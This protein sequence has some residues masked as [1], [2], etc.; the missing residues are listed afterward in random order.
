MLQLV[1]FAMQQLVEVDMKMSSHSFFIFKLGSLALA[2]N[3][4][5]VN[6]TQLKSQLEGQG[7]IFQTSSDTEVLAH[8]I[9]RG[10]ILH[11]KNV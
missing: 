7:S 8:L 9:R 2:H 3:G 5:L 10:G 1:M 4:N 6:A 11:L